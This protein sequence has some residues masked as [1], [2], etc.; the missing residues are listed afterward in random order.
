MERTNTLELELA[1]TPDFSDLVNH[2]S[3]TNTLF[4][5]DCVF[6]LP[7]P[8]WPFSN[9]SGSEA[10]WRLFESAK[11]EK[12]FGRLA[13]E[14]FFSGFPN[15]QLFPPRRVERLAGANSIFKARPYQKNIQTGSFRIWKELGARPNSLVI[16][17]FD[18]N[19]VADKNRAC[20]LEV[21]PSFLWKKFLNTRKRKPELLLEAI[22]NKLFGQN[23]RLSQ[24]TRQQL[25]A[26]VD[27]C[28][29]SIA[30]LSAYRLQR[31]SKLLSFPSESFVK[32][33]GWILG[34]EERECQSIEV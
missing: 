16:L 27:F 34:V 1:L 14:T 18:L 9:C 13:A 31:E 4:L 28:D 6:G 7:E 19:Q 21:Y 17:P 32:K 20:I 5:V 12:A 10:L 2:Y 15:S 25:Q 24:N 30:A 29:A 8:S 26:S 33:E 3:N 23:I 11:G 22:E